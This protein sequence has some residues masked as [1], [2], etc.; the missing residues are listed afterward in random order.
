MQRCMACVSSMIC[1]LSAV[2]IFSDL[3]VVSLAPG[4]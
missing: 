4:R 3:G 2:A 1:L